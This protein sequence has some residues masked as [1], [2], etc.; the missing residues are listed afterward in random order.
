MS[1]DVIDRL[2]DRVANTVGNP[3]RVQSLTPTQ[4]VLSMIE[5]H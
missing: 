2:A 1:D 3:I 4:G 5:G